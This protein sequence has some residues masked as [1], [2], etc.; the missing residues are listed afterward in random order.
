M[1]IRWRKYERMHIGMYACM[2][3]DA[4]ALHLFDFKRFANRL[5]IFLLPIHHWLNREHLISVLIQRHRF[6]RLF[7]Y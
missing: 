6:T 1:Y 2:H 7:R 3:V 5:L 4:H